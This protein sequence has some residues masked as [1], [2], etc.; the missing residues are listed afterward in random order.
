MRMQEL[1]EKVTFW[2]QKVEEPDKIQDE[3]QKAEL[4]LAE[5]EA[6]NERRMSARQE[7]VELGKEAVTLGSVHITCGKCKRKLAVQGV[8]EIIHQMKKKILLVALCDKCKFKPTHPE[9]TDLSNRI[10]FVML[11]NAPSRLKPI[12]MEFHDAAKE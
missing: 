2:K 12:I 10:N 6:E 3:L 5:A 11:D 1:K 8:Q 4:E 9:S 7:G